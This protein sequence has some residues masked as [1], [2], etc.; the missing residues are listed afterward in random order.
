MTQQREDSIVTASRQI[1]TIQDLSAFGG[2][3]LTAVL[4]ILA[5]MGA[6]TVP[7]PT[8]LLSAHTGGFGEVVFRD[9]TDFL[10][11][12]L[13]HYTRIGLKPCCVYSGFLGSEDQ[14]GL[15]AEYFERFPDAL[16]V[17]DPVMGDDGKPYR[18]YTEPMC[19][20]MT[21]LVRK[22]DV[23]TPNPT[24]AALLL[25]TDYT[26]EPVTA[27]QAR[28][29]LRGLAALGPR[30]AVITGIRIGGEICNIGLDAE[31]EEYRKVPCRYLPV[32]YPGTGDVFAAVLV[33][34]MTAGEPLP[35]AM[36]RATGFVEAAVR[37]TYASGRDP[38]Q[39]IM[40]EKCLPQLIGGGDSQR[41][42]VL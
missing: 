36:S 1:I 28:Q 35:T 20:R 19:R 42:E 41:Y 7:V 24:E 16:A 18:T 32:K 6:Q 29:M 37:M 23:I 11:R 8:A 17:V 31:H 4:P 15:T 12:T 34:A 22:A 10:R 14:I 40:V 33:G 38:R 9:E 21:E 2:C 30:C 5:A 27:P 25:G 3:S 39:G 13:A 26:P